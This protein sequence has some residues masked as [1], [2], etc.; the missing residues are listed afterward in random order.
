MQL[1]EAQRNGQ[2]YEGPPNVVMPVEI[3]PGRT[4]VARPRN[5]ALL[6]P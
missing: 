2:P 1:I 6:I 3:V 5:A 4:L